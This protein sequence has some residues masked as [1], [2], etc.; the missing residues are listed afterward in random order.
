MLQ[1]GQSSGSGLKKKH[2]LPIVT[3]FAFPAMNNKEDETGHKFSKDQTLEKIR[4]IQAVFC[5]ER[6]WDQFHPPRDVLFDLIGEVGELAEIFRFKGHV[7]V[8]LPEFS[9]EE[10]DHV[11]Q[12]MSDVLLS[13]LRLAE[14][15]HIDLPTA[16]LQKF[17][18]N[19]EKYPIHR[20]YGKINKPTE[21]AAENDG[22]TGTTGK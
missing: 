5:R 8:G 14:R 2:V 15:C 18:L 11:G 22:K 6:N 13:L 19:R 10:R 21:N 4:E 9:E 7:E 12:E 1:V 20:A 3:T 16:V 17:Q